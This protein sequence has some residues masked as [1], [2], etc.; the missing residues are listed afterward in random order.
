[1][2]IN[3]KIS[4]CHDHIY[5][6]ADF[7]DFSTSKQPLTESESCELTQYCFFRNRYI[8]TEERYIPTEV[9][10]R[11]FTLLSPTDLY[12][13]AS[14]VCWQWNRISCSDSLLANFGLKELFPSLRII[15]AEV[16]KKS[17]LLENLELDLT[18]APSYDTVATRLKLKQL[19]TPGVINGN[20]GATI[21]TIPKGHSI[22][23][24][25]ELSES[26]SYKVIVNCEREYSVG[27]PASLNSKLANRTYN[28]IL[29]ND[30]LI[31]TLEE[32]IESK[33][34]ILSELG[35]QLP[36]LMAAMTC[37]I[38]ILDV[39]D[40]PICGINKEKANSQKTQLFCTDTTTSQAKHPISI[41][42]AFE[43]FNGNRI[44][45]LHSSDNR[46][47]AGMLA[48]R[49]GAMAMWQLPDPSTK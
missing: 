43:G 34:R 15:D 24:C 36:N 2:S 41:S 33:K 28:V 3:S 9:W 27:S 32:S 16:W 6:S 39:L 8:P 4:A 26:F 38:M 48:K 21:L 25:F 42:I 29:T 13:R 17:I 14:Q 19:Y 45:T 49:S 7:K 18:E 46:I 31:G 30:F 22:G 1:M 23:K 20:S 47:D 5:N 37:A 11:V 35:C 44:I 40:E 10:L 12:R